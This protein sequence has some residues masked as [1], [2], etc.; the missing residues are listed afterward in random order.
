MNGEQVIRLAG[1]VSECARL[2]SIQPRDIQPQNDIAEQCVWLYCGK[3]LLTRVEY[4]QLM[5]D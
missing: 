3:E 5:E 1:Q 4:S 2:H